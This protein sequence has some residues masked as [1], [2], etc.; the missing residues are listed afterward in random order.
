VRQGPLWCAWIDD[1]AAV[2]ARVAYAVGRPVGTAVARNRLRRRLRA[3]VADCDATR[4]LPA[5]WYLLGAAPAASELSAA[6]LHGA[7]ATLFLA[8]P[9]QGR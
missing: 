9:H 7:V 3:A 8:L 2:P 6:E 4:P 1:Q 5:G